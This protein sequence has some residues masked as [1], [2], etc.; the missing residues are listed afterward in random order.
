LFGPA[1]G[2]LRGHRKVVNLSRPEPA[3]RFTDAS[4]SDIGFL[5][6]DWAFGL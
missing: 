2:A 5:G 4:G 3:F 6:L 1:A